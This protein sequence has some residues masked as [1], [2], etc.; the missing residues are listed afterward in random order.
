MAGCGQNLERERVTGKIFWNKELAAAL[1]ANLLAE[2]WRTRR[3]C[4]F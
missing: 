1:V 2:P 4:A 3:A